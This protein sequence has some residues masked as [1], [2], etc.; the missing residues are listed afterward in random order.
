MSFVTLLLDKK[1]SVKE[2]QQNNAQNEQIFSIRIRC[3]MFI[4][5][6]FNSSM[7]NV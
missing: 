1:P 4:S 6:V 7:L 2:Q 5:N 3:L